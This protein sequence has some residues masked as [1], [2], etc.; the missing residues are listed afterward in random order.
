MRHL[1]M[2]ALFGAAMLTGSVS[3]AAAETAPAATI[4]QGRLAGARTGDVERFLDIPFAAAPVGALRWRAPQAPPRWRK[5]RPGLS[6][7]GAPRTCRGRG[8][9]A[10]V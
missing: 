8:S 6:A 7:D 9:R 10:S 2:A 5:T 4:A 1:V 3:V